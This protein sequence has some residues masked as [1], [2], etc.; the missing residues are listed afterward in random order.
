MYYGK[1]IRVSPPPYEITSAYDLN[2]QHGTWHTVR[3][4][5][6]NTALLLLLLLFLCY[7]N[8]STFHVRKLK[9][10]TNFDIFCGKRDRLWSKGFD[11][12]SNWLNKAVNEKPITHHYYK[13]LYSMIKTIKTT[14]KLIPE[15]TRP[16]ISTLWN[17]ERGRKW[18]LFHFLIVSIFGK[19]YVQSVRNGNGRCCVKSEPSVW[20]FVCL[21]A[22]E[23]PTEKH[24]IHCE[25]N[26]RIV[27]IYI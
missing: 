17:I 3:S 24:F 9:R 1:S 22:F 7:N 15:K 2:R 11:S 6:L 21:F 26:G 19:N 14:L 13:I 16:R 27:C 5:S 18:L 10:K 4:S 25:W 12:L 23:T 20:Y 8:N